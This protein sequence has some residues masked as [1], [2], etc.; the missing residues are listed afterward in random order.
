M[1][2]F[3]RDSESGE[4]DDAKSLDELRSELE[5][6]GGAGNKSI[7]DDYGES[8]HRNRYPKDIINLSI[9][10]YN[11][12]YAKMIIPTKSSGATFTASGWN[13]GGDIVRRTT[14]K[15]KVEDEPWENY[16]KKLTVHEE[17]V[18]IGVT[19][20]D[21]SITSDNR[22]NQTMR[23]ELAD[24]SHIRKQSVEATTGFMLETPGDVYQFK[25]SRKGFGRRAKSSDANEAVRHLKNAVKNAPES[26]EAEPVSEGSEESTEGD[27]I[28]K[29]SRVKELYDDGVLTE[30]EFQEK[31]SELLDHI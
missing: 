2:L 5:K 25:L 27:A 4:D 30:E 1:G 7:P 22:I 14:S 15:G 28:D 20:G 17:F 21:M 31:K 18:E 29:L 26:E 13:I 23:I 10:T 9:G 3:S 11:K 19:Y 16:V 12:L 24:I 6:R 8:D